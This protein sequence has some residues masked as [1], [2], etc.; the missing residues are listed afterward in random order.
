MTGKATA[1]LVSNNIV[2]IGFL[3]HRHVRARRRN[4]RDIEYRSQDE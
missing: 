3:P 1:K 4:Y 2:N